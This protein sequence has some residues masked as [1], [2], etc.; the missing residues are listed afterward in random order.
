MYVYYVLNKRLIQWIVIQLSLRLRNRVAVIALK[1]ST[2]Q[3]PQH[4]PRP[5]PLLLHCSPVARVRVCCTP[6]G[7]AG[8]HVYAFASALYDI[9]ITLPLFPPSRT[10]FILL[11]CLQ[12]LSL[13]VT[14]HFVLNVSCIS[15]NLRLG[16]ILYYLMTYPSLETVNSLK[17]SMCF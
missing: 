8:S 17:G 5:S 1:P 14:W 6:K 11:I 13:P 16:F 15:Y 10:P 7:H 3:L 2:E 12:C 4:S 9:W